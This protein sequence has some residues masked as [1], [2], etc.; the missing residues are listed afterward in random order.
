M[1]NAE[2]V[3]LFSRKLRAIFKEIDPLTVRV[4]L[5]GEKST[6]AFKQR[7]GNN[8]LHFRA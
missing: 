2:V 5:G 8:M 7:G 3:L 1:H 6:M 4:W